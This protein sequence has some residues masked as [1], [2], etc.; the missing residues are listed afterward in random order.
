MRMIPVLIGLPVMDRIFF[1]GLR[2]THNE[3]LI[4]ATEGSELY[5]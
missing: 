2:C 1:V 3:E 4:E 5:N